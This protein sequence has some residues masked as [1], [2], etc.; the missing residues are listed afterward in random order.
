MANQWSLTATFKLQ[1]SL[2]TQTLTRTKYGAQRFG[3][4][5]PVRP[6]EEKS[7]TIQ[8]QPQVFKFRTYEPPT[9]LTTEEKPV[10]ATAS[11]TYSFIGELH[12][13]GF[14][15]DNCPVVTSRHGNCLARCVLLI[16]T[17]RGKE[18]HLHALEPRS[19]ELRET[20]GWLFSGSRHGNDGC[21][22]PVLFH[23][24]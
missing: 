1:S 15:T 6:L 2:W 23:W 24:S 12:R 18:V 16:P 11:R 3:L 8:V 21:D 13:Q 14:P 10:T 20:F 7:K 22:W 4:L 9:L 19:N 5:F 17:G